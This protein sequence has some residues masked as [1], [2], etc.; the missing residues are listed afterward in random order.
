MS[1]TVLGSPLPSVI[2]DFF[3]E[4]FEKCALALF[5]LKPLYKR[6]ADDTLLIWP[7]GLDQLDAFVSHLNSLS[8]TIRFTVEV[9]VG[10]KVPF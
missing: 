4:A 7:Y 6:Y 2:A 10:G 8:D 3:M 1:K 9:D 5:P